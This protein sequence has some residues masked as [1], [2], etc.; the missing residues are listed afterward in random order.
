MYVEMFLMVSG[1]YIAKH[2]DK[3]IF[4]NKFKEAV[5][6]TVNKYIPLILYAA[7]P[8]IVAYLVYVY[9]SFL[10]VDYKRVVMSIGGGLQICY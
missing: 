6:Y 9:K 10:N 2:Y 7:G 1:F 5:L 8:T 4:D 3:S